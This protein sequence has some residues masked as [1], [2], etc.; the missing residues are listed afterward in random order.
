MF[1]RPD[2][3]ASV[4]EKEASHCESRNGGESRARVDAAGERVCGGWGRGRADGLGGLGCACRAAGLGETSAHC[5]AFFF[6]N[7]DGFGYLLGWL[8]VGFGVMMFGGMDGW[9]GACEA[10]VEVSS[11]L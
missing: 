1:S 10:E 2:R 4:D 7:G 11:V 3:S 8:G 5:F 9:M 6:F